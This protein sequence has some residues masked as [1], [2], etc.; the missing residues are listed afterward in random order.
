[1]KRLTAARAL[2][3]LH[4]RRQV[5]GGAAA[6]VRVEQQLL[7][8]LLPRLGRSLARVRKEDVERHLAI[9]TGEVRASTVARE[10]SALRALY[11]ALTTAGA[12]A[13]DPTSGLGL[14]AD[15]PQQLVLSEAAVAE[16]LAAGSL[17]PHVRRAPEVRDALALRN[18]AALE[19]LYGLG[20]RASEVCNTRVLDLHLADG[21]L[22]VRRAKRGAW[23]R[24]P[25]PPAT[26]PH[27][28]AYLTEARPVLVQAGDRS[29]GRL[30][31]TERG[32]RLR[33]QRLEVIVGRAAERAGV[34]AHP[35]ALRRSVATHLVQRGAALP[36][37]QCLLGHRRLDTTQRYVVMSAAD[38]RA[39]V[40]TL[41]R[42]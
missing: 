36:A 29:E 39:A 32:G 31:V 25:V 20:L 30:L 41:D 8:R 28:A 7:G 14:K 21:S 11:Q 3:I 34:R 27:L 40:E 37:V 35:H 10:L 4:R 12:V 33:V 24:L 5:Q 18:R 38:L 16:L 42:G 19:L 22:L 17:P 6:T 13:E 2:E 1:L 9:R 26:L 15:S 23:A